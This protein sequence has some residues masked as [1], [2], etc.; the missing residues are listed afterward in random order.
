MM[1]FF[2]IFAG[3]HLVGVVLAENRGDPGLISNMV[4]GGDPQR[5]P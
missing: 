1:W 5:K 3:G 4:H 2:V